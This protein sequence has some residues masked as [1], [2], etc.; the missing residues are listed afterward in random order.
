[1]KIICVGKNY[2]KHIDELNSSK[3]DEPVI[4]LKPDTSIIQKNQPF[5]IPEFSNEIHYEIEI[6]LK[7]NRLGKHIESKFSNKY[8]NQISLGIDFTARDFQNKFKDRG[9]PWDISKGFDNSAL[10]GDWKS[11]KTYDLDNINFRL[12]KNGKIVQQS[13]SKNMIWKIDELIAYASKYFTIKIGDIMF[14]GTPEG[15]GVVS[16]DDVLEGFLGDE[17]VFSVKIK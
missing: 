8:F 10:I 14:T 9:L 4:F 3:E 7:F 13:N 17:K 2:L 15:V 6:I 16:E 12:E 5:F 1:M 11:I